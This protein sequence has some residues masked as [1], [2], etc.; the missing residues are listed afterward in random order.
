MKV[1]HGDEYICHK[2]FVGS[3]RPMYLKVIKELK[4]MLVPMLC[5]AR[6]ES[7]ENFGFVDG[8]CPGDFQHDSAAGYLFSY[9]VR[10]MECPMYSWSAMS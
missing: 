4:D 2:S 10:A 6:G 5:G 1:L 8:I 9:N 7:L 3:I